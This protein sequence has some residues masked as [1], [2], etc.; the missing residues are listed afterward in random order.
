[1]LW[2]QRRF[3]ENDRDQVLPFAITELSAA[4]GLQRQRLFAFVDGMNTRNRFQV[5]SF[6]KAELPAGMELQSPRPNRRSLL[7]S[8][9]VCRFRV[10]AGPAVEM[11]LTSPV[12]LLCGFSRRLGASRQGRVAGLNGEQGQGSAE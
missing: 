8:P 7:P 11:H 4:G 10:G 1:M 12:E 2:V 6:A 5:M 3:G 9:W